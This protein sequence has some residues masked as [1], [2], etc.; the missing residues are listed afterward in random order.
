[1]PD[2]IPLHTETMFPD[3]LPEIRIRDILII[4]VGAIITYG[5]LKVTGMTP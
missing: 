4:M 5:I 3:T 1:M 2:R